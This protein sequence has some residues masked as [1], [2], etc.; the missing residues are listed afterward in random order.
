MKAVVFLCG[1]TATSIA[2]SAHQQLL[3]VSLL[4]SIAILSSVSSSTSASA[5]VEDV[6]TPSSCYGGAARDAD[7]SCPNPAFDDHDDD[8]DSS[9]DSSDDATRTATTDNRAATPPFQTNRGLFK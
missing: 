7:G 9:D 5:V 6:D 2:T 1:L 8:E 4:V 3:P